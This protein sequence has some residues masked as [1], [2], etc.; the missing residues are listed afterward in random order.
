[1]KEDTTHLRKKTEDEKNMSFIK[2][3]MPT[4]T[5]SMIVVFLLL[6]FIGNV[7]P[8]SIPSLNNNHWSSRTG[9]ISAAP[10]G[11]GK[12]RNNNNNN[13][14]NIRASK[15]TVQNVK[16]PKVENDAGALTK[17]M[18]LP[19]S[20]Y[21]CVP[22]PLDSSLSRRTNG[23]ADEFELIVP[24][25]QLKSPGVPIVEVR[26]IIV[27]SVVVEENRIIITSNSCEIR[28]SKL[29]QDLKM[30]DYFDFEIK[31]FM[32]YIDNSSSNKNTGSIM[33]KSE[34]KIDLDPPGIFG[35]VP[36][37]ILEAVGNRA[38]GVT[39]EALQR[40]FIKSL[41]KDYERWSCDKSY[42]IQ[43]EKMESQEKGKNNN[44]DNINDTLMTYLVNR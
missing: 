13:K 32:T 15:R 11:I 22:M 23:A 34:I 28:G 6:L 39:L 25:I 4:L 30:N 26:P 36:R 20:Q 27:A 10:R 14:A 24:P 8:L 38:I 44:V 33:A 7:A 35:L 12:T 37:S 9:R 16:T 19:A 21:T 3:L 31:L 41:G 29:I 40:D 1:M 5:F 43:R 18:R 17:Y 42:R 2:R